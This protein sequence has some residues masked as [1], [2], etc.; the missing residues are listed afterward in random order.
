M[1]HSPLSFDASTLEFW[2]SLLHGS[3]LV[4]APQGSLGLDD[5]TQL[6]RR[7]RG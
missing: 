1:L 4:V 2:G 5:Y 3:R 7:L 6:I